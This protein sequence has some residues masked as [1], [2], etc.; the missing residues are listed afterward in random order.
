MV[1]SA[2]A[3]EPDLRVF[4]MF[5]CADCDRLLARI[6]VIPDC[7]TK[8]EIKCAKCKAINLFQRNKVIVTRRRP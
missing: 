5:R 1:M 4:S 7:S 8:I 6:Y 3:K 2:K